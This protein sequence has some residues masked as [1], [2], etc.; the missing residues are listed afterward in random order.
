MQ[1]TFEVTFLKNKF[2]RPLII[3]VLYSNLFL[4]AFYYKNYISFKV[5][6]LNLRKRTF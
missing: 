5:E 3:L 4:G 6:S 1:H 2:I